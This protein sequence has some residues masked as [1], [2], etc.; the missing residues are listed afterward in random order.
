MHLT[1]LKLPQKLSFYHIFPCS[2][3]FLW[4]ISKY[5]ISCYCSRQNWRRKSF[6]ML[7]YIIGWFRW[8]HAGTTL[9]DLMYVEKGCLLS[10]FLSY[11]TCI[12]RV[13]HSQLLGSLELMSVKFW[14]VIDVLFQHIVR[15][16][17]FINTLHCVQ[18]LILKY[19]V[20]NKSTKYLYLEYHL[21]Q[22]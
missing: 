12:F 1:K 18:W 7:P 19:P 8:K 3:N 4:P 14:I 22:I 10:F 17:E 6:I 11:T 20:L 5:Y 21:F 15:R 16:L 2:T 13:V 9:E